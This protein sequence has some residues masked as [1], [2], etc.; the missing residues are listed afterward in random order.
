[1]LN[2][3]TV[4]LEKRKESLLTIYLMYKYTFLAHEVVEMDI[5]GC[6]TPISNKDP[7]YIH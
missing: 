2:D 6:C 1:M 3:V 7:D 4:T 5:L